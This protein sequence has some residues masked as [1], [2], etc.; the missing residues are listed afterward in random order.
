M[1]LQLISKLTPQIVELEYVSFE[2]ADCSRCIHINVISYHEEAGAISKE[3]SAFIENVDLNTLVYDNSRGKYLYFQENVPE[4]TKKAMTTGA[5]A[6]GKKIF[7]YRFT[8]KRYNAFNFLEKFQQHIKARS[9]TKTKQANLFY[10]FGVE[11]ETSAGVIPEHLCFQNGLIPVYDGSITG[12]EYASVVLK[13]VLGL[14]TVRNQFKLYEQYSKI[15]ADC[16]IHVHLGGLPQS[17]LFAYFLHNVCFNLQKVLPQYLHP[18][19]FNSSAYKHSEKNY[20][21]DLPDN[22]AFDRYYRYISGRDLS[23]L[24]SWNPTDPHASDR[25]GGHKW[26]IAQRYYWLNVINLLYYNKNKTIEFRCLPATMSPEKLI[27]WIYIF[28]AIA[29]YAEVIYQNFLATKPG[30]YEASLYSSPGLEKSTEIATFLRSQKLFS[31]LQEV[32]GF[33][34]SDYSLLNQLNK[35]LDIQK[36]IADDIGNPNDLDNGKVDTLHLKNFTFE[37]KK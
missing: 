20:S 5:K 6:F 9:V 27:G 22:I 8:E 4:G 31:S 28:N 29:K 34:Y 23:S 11:Y 1:K 37:K 36:K 17:F 14:Q 32:L 10:T 18:W 30:G 19:I 24:E 3:Y 13:G 7:P 21:K 33:I 25:D 12:I 26:N 35:F 2:D 15:N 16:S